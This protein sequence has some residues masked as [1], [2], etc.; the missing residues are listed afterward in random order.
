MTLKRKISK[1]Y[2]EKNLNENFTVKE[3]ILLSSKR[4]LIHTPT[5]GLLY[6]QLK[7]T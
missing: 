2:W 5:A 1:A 7:V 4:C 3:L 6:Q